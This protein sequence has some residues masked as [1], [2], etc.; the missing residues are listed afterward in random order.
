MQNTKMYKFQMVMQGWE[1]SPQK[2]VNPNV[3]YVQ[4]TKMCMYVKCVSQSIVHVEL[5]C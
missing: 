2:D 5:H 4:I 1:N 3:Q